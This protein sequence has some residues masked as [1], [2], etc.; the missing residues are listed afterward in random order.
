MTP[1]ATEAWL[2][3][4][5]SVVPPVDLVMMNDGM[6]DLTRLPPVDSRDELLATM[7]ARR[8]YRGFSPVEPVPIDYVRDCLWAGFG[9]TAFAPSPFDDHPAFPLTTTPSGGARN[10]FEGYLYARH[11]EGL[12]EGMYHYCGVDNTLGLVR[13]PPLP[14]VGALL[15]GQPWF[16]RAGALILLVAHFQRTMWKYPHPTGY[17]V[18]LLQAGHIAQNILLVA[19]ARGLAATPTCAVSDRLVHDV[20]GLD[21]ITEGVVYS[22]SIGMRSDQP[23]QA[24]LVSVLPNPLMT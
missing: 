13:E 4:H 9:V 19:T 6:R 1:A 17:R 20:I 14:A 12:R 16:D 22:V 21:P 23:T 11:V 8:S 3:S 5:A 10:P 18:V 24:D 7:R 15:A 2:E